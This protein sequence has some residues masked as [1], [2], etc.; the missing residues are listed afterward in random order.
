MAA[1][2]AKERERLRAAIAMT[3]VGETEERPAVSE[4]PWYKKWWVYAVAGGVLA[5]GAVGVAI[6]YSVQPEE[7]D[8]MVHH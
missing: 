2:T 7:V 5:A 1:W 8:L 4:K 6:A 3:L